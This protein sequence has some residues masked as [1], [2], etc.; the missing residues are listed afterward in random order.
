M[1]FTN[2]TRKNRTNST[3]KKIAS[4]NALLAIY[5][6]YAGIKITG[7]RFHPIRHLT[8]VCS[9]LPRSVIRRLYYSRLE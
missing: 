2:K 4:S 1:E 9:G 3:N 6:I 7:L 8:S 5:L